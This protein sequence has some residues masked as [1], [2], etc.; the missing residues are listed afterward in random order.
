ML[1]IEQDLQTQGVQAIAGVDEAGRGPL[2]GPVVAAAVILPFPCPIEGIRDSKKLSEKKRE[3]LFELIQAQCHVGVGCVSAEIIDQINIL[4]AARLAMK[5][6]VQA[7]SMTPDIL[8]IDGPIRLDLPMR[9]RSIIGGDRIC[10]SIAAASII[11]KVTR[12]RQML[13]Y[14]EQY[15]NYAFSQHKGY[16]TQYHMECL[17]IHGPSPIHRK[18][19]GPV[20]AVLIT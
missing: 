15:P 8:L 6:A 13:E 11:A 1:P 19:F 9:M 5:Q 7:L 20:K 12:D 16:P 4:Q 17:K 3:K 14:H 18:S 10:Q 2:A